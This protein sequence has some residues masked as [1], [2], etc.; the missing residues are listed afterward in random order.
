[1]L[2]LAPPALLALHPAVAAP[3]SGSGRDVCCTHSPQRLG[4][5]L[6]RP[7]E[8][9]SL[10]SKAVSCMSGLAG[11]GDTEM[12]GMLLS[13]SGCRGP[14][15]QADPLPALDLP[16][17]YG[18]RRRSSSHMPG[19]L[20]TPPSRNACTHGVGRTNC[21]GRRS[22]AIRRHIPA[23]KHWRDKEP[24]VVASPLCCLRAHAGFRPGL[25]ARC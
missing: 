20:R 15:P 4:R 12:Q 22:S 25:Y 17:E 14:G 2:G 19:P 6:C 8:S 18:S 16:R 13:Q 24:Q 5:G 10:V 11:A 21:R 9:T 23:A 3:D 7:A 1:M